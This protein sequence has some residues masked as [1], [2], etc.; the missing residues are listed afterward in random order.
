MKIYEAHKVSSQSNELAEIK[1]FANPHKAMDELTKDAGCYVEWKAFE[2]H[3]AGLTSN[4][5]GD[6]W[7]IVYIRDVIE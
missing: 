3:W 2:Y 5:P 6:D 7:Y 1:W 4:N